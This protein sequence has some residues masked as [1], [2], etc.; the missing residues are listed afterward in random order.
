[1]TDERTLIASL[2]SFAAFGPLR[3]KL[4]LEFF[5][6]AGEVWNTKKNEL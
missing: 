5:G 2:S 3:L 6:T 1:M 4:F